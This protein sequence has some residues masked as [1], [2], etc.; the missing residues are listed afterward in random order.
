[1]TSRT[2][3]CA[4]S[5]CWNGSRSGRS[6]TSSRHRYESPGGTVV[7]RVNI[8]AIRGGEPWMILT[9]PEVCML[10]LDIR[11]APGQDGGAIRHELRALMDEC[12]LEGKVEQFVNRNGYEA[13]RNRT[14][15]GR[16]RRGTPE[17]LRR[18][19][20]DR[21][22]AG[23]QHVARPQRLQRDGHSGADVRAARPRRDGSVCSR[24]GDLLNAARVYAL[25]ALALCA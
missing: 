25:T 21:G 15:R 9:N 22:L 3:S 12:G 20:R 17:R 7:P 24:A 1:M 2:R 23:V 10:Y 8:S 13:Q 14:A 11:T 16:G 6:T 4:P 18:G 5:P 19:V